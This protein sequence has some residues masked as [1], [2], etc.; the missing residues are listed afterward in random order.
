M[1]AQ[2]KGGSEKQNT[3]ASQ[4]ATNWIH[5]F[6]EE[7]NAAKARPESDMVGGYVAN[8]EKCR[9]DL[10]AGLEK[11][12]SAKVIE[13]HQAKVSPVAALIKKAQAK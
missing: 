3:W 7:L 5:Q 1:N 4:I 9:A 2:I 6:D 13:M 8:L 12:T 11:I 10:L